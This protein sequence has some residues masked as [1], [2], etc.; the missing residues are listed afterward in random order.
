MVFWKLY[1]GTLAKE[2]SSVL[3]YGVMVTIAGDY[4]KWIGCFVSTVEWNMVVPFV[5]GWFGSDMY[6]LV[7][8]IYVNCIVVSV[9][10]TIVIW[11]K[12]LWILYNS[13][14]FCLESYISNINDIDLTHFTAIY[15]HDEI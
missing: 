8:T 12:K 3:P 5:F 11:L 6:T 9:L 7:F 14:E 10:V 2:G 13:H 15:K 4:D 1:I